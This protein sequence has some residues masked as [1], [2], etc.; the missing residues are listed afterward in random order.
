MEIKSNLCSNATRKIG[1]LITKASELGMDVSGYGFAD[2]NT[3]SGN[4]YIW[5][6]DYNFTLYIGL[7]SDTIYALW[8]NSEDGEEIELDVTGKTLND[9]DAWVEQNELDASDV[10]HVWSAVEIM[11]NYWILEDQYGAEYKDEEGDNRMFES[12]EEAEAFIATLEA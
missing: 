8:T 12:K 1:L 7:G 9:I 11:D 2:E 5:L 4:V 10:E 6:E 3:N